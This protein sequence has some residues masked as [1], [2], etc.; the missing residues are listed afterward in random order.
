MSSRVCKRLEN[1][2]AIKQPPGGRCPLRVG[3]NG[4]ACLGRGEARDTAP[5]GALIRELEESD[6]K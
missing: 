2:A 5:R 1:N 6:S 4:S 3:Q